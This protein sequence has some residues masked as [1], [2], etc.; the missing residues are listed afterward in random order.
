M[1]LQTGSQVLNGIP[2]FGNGKDGNVLTRTEFVGDIYSSTSFNLVKYEINP[3]IY[4][5]YPWG[6]GVAKNYVQW[7]PLGEIW[8]FVSQS[9]NALNSTN[10]GLGN[11]AMTVEYDVLAP[12]FT[13][14]RQVLNNAGTVNQKP[15]CNF[16]LPVECQM[17]DR[18]TNVLYTRSEEASD[19][20]KLQSDLGSVYVAT[21]GMQ[22]AGVLI[23]KLYHSYQIELLKPQLPEE[24]PG[25]GMGLGTSGP[26]GRILGATSGSFVVFNTLGA[27]VHFGADTI[28]IPMNLGGV[29]NI[30]IQYSGGAA[31][32][33]YTA[34]GLTGSLGVDVATYSNLWIN[35]GGTGVAWSQQFI[36]A[37]DSSIPIIKTLYFGTAAGGILATSYN[38][39]KVIMDQLPDD[40]S[41]FEAS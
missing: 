35:S 41:Q 20:K 34:I 1:G 30:S 25:G 16:R 5:S 33:T 19:A 6:S 27:T 40:I 38:A 13:N 26:A 17:V 23:G 29:Y 7:R 36:V 4:D 3:G 22:E 12:I 28:D 31:G 39:V 18:P 21:E 11:V 32:A 14:M 10:T 24:I 2:S 9:S 8:D 37:F 15:S